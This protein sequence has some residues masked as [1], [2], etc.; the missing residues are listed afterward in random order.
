LRRGRRGANGRAIVAGGKCAWLN[1]V[2]KIAIELHDDTVFGNATEIFCNAIRGQNFE[3][4]RS[5]ELTIC[6]RL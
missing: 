5:G 3:I 6:S 2:D 4:S 1:Q